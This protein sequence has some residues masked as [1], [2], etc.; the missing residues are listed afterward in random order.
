MSVV[1]GSLSFVR[2]SMLSL[3]FLLWSMYMYRPFLLF[4]ASLSVFSSIH[5][6]PFLLP[7][8]HI[9][10]VFLYSSWG[11]WPCFHC[12]CR[13]FFCL[14]S[15]MPIILKSILFYQII[16]KTLNQFTCCHVIASALMP[17]TRWYTT[18]IM[19]MTG[20]RS[21]KKRQRFVL[22]LMLHWPGIKNVFIGLPN[23]YLYPPCALWLY[24]EED[25]HWERGRLVLPDFWTCR[26][27]T[28][29]CKV[30]YLIFSANVNMCY[31]VQNIFKAANAALHF[32]YLPLQTFRWRVLIDLWIYAAHCRIVM[33]PLWV[34]LL[35]VKSLL[36]SFVG[37]GLVCK[38]SSILPVLQEFL[39]CVEEILSDQNNSRFP[40]HFVPCSEHPDSEASSCITF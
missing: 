35:S 34:T 1:T 36:G 38:T 28:I 13:F 40:W 25:F 11:T 18:I 10:T 4:F 31:K 15:S 30:P 20:E 7:S 6:L 39:R 14:I 19:L 17:T 2:G 33:L 32:L 8:L 23:P 12:P 26:H 24:Y 5:A 16:Q 22:F 27:N 9:W 21:S 29:N 37:T 3:V